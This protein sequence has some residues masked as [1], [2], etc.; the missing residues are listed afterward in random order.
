MPRDITI[1]L[2]KRG[3][4]LLDGFCSALERAVHDSLGKGVPLGLVVDVGAGRGEL[5][6]RLAEHDLEC[7]G[8]DPEADC[9]A[10]ASKPGRCKQGG[11]EDL[12][13]VI[14]DQVPRI[15]V[16]SHVLEH[17]NSPY[18]AIRTMY[19]TGATELVL[20]VA[21]VLRIARLIRA[22]F[23]RRRGDYPEHVYA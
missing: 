22:L 12:Q 3:A 15:I 4:E 8:I 7:L 11:I 13:Q 18:D 10:M 19:Q 23:G 17:L 20:A 14:I 9:V 2:D 1:N 21:N 6:Q 5:L 16:C